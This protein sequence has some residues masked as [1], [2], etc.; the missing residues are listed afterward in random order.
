[1]RAE[2][3][4]LVL[5]FRGVDRVGLPLGFRTDASNVTLG[6]LA[7][8]RLGAALRVPR[9]SFDFPGLDLA[10]LGV[11][12]DLRFDYPPGN[13]KDNVVNT[14]HVQEI[15][16]RNYSVREGWLSATF[17]AK[18]VSGHLGGG[19]YSGYVNGGGMLPFT[20]GPISGWVAATDIDLAPIGAAL[21]GK[22]AEMTGQAHLSATAEVLG[23]RLDRAKGML[24]LDRLPR[25][26]PSWRRD[27]ARI[28]VETL[29]EYPY[30]RGDGWLEFADYRGEA[31]LSLDGERGSRLI[32]IHYDQEVRA[33]TL[34]TGATQ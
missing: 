27:L 1:V 28:A 18:G 19:A 32:E 2:F 20:S 5:T 12:G 10:L 22:Y 15:R 7:S 26:T 33:V 6:D 30:T 4:R 17:D 14:L 3:G 8:L 16:W 31:Q 23:G 13:V 9:Q 24:T 21:A 11:E 34:A 25:D 29:R